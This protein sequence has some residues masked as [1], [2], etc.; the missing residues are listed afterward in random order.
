MHLEADLGRVAGARDQLGEPSDG[1]WRAPLGNK[2]EG[3]LASRFRARSARISSPSSGCVLI[4]PPLA[5]RMCSVALSNSTSVHCSL[6]SSL[7]RKAW[8]KPIRSMQLFLAPWRLPLAAAISFSTS[9]SVRCSRGLSS[10]F[11]RRRGVT[12]RF[13][14]VGAT[15]R[16]LGLCVIFATPRCDSVHILTEIRTVCRSDHSAMV[17]AGFSN[18]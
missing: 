14:L 13:S 17:S 1:E 4:V 10:L 16:R 2:N 3:R 7:A 18:T 6:Q 5:R 9:R 8:R 11:G 15:S 12:V